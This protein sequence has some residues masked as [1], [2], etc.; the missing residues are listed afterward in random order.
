MGTLLDLFPK[1]HTMKKLFSAKQ[2]IKVIKQH[3]ADTH[4]ED[5]YGQLGTPNGTFYNRRCKHVGLEVN[6]AERLRE[7]ES[8]NN[9]LNKLL[10]EK[11]LE[12]KAMNDIFTKVMKP[13]ARKEIIIELTRGYHS[14]E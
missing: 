7:L 1:I 5:I 13:S 3:E 4:V 12:N 8:E 14:M 6:E 10:A 11:H 2:I 9:K